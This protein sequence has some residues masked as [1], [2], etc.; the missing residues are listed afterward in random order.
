MTDDL[1][2]L[3]EGPMAAD[4]EERSIEQILALEEELE[5]SRTLSASKIGELEQ[6]LLEAEARA[7]AAER[8]VEESRAQ[9][10]KLERALREAEERAGTQVERVEPLIT[11]AKRQHGDQE[12]AAIGEPTLQKSASA[13]PVSLSSATFEDLRGLGLSV[14]QAKRVLHFREHL[15]GFDSV[16]DLDQVLGLPRS[17]LAELKRRTTV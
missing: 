13:P 5:R 7:I 14:T 6:R 4:L 12:V 3:N 1:E 16:D 15:D 9:V 17:L 8:D 10:A 11:A 2:I